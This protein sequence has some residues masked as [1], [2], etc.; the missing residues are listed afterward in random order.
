[1]SLIVLLYN[2]LS[3]GIVLLGTIHMLTTAVLT[4]SSA[5]GR[6]WFF[7][8][9]IAMVLTGALNLLNRV[10]GAGAVGVLWVCIGSNVLMSCFAVVAGVSTNAGPAQFI[11]VLGLV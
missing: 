2:T 1:M 3:W 8:A 9:G 7:G 11:V 4:G 5:A 10:Y 6:V